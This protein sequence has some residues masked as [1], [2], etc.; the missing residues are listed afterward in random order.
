M[1]QPRNASVRRFAA[2]W[3]A[4]AVWKV[5]ALAAFLVLVLHLTAAGGR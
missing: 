3:T 1:P 4:S 5:T 2:V